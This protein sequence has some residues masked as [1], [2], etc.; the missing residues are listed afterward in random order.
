MP[1]LS[2]HFALLEHFFFNNYQKIKWKFC[3]EVLMWAV[4]SA[5]LSVSNDSSHLQGISLDSH[6]SKHLQ[7]DLVSQFSFDNNLL[8]GEYVCV[9]CFFVCRFSPFTRKKISSTLFKFRKKN[10]KLIFSP[11]VAT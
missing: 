10:P 5:R 7:G 6:V 9:V 11:W 1:M 2:E 3:K 8:R 4:I